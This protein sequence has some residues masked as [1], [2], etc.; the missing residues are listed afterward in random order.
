MAGK[1]ENTGIRD[2]VIVLGVLALFAITYFILRTPPMVPL[3]PNQVAAPSGPSGHEAMGGMDQLGNLPTNFEGLV[4]VGNQSFDAGNYAVAAE[5][6]RRA[7]DING[8]DDNVRTDFGACLH[9]MG[10]DERALEE[11]RTVMRGTE[12][13]AI[14]RFN[15]GIVHNDMGNLDSAKFYFNQYLKMDPDGP[16]AQQAKTILEKMNQSKP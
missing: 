7:L 2:L 11:F 13:H 16:A 12:G 8:S 6:Y 4:G 15:A 1:I 10:L 3:P 9:F 5:C 14:A